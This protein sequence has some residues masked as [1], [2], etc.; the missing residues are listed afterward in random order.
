MVLCI[1]GCSKDD[2]AVIPEAAVTLAPTFEPT[3]TPTVKVK[4]ELPALENAK[5]RP[6]AK[7]GWLPVFRQAIGM[8]EKCIAIT[9]DD[10]FQAGNMRSI[11]EL[12][13]EYGGK[14]TFFP[15]GK[16]ALLTEQ[17]KILREAYANG[18]EIENHTYTHN[19]LY[20]GTDEELAQEIYT[21]QLVL[22]YVLG[23]DYT[24]HF[25]RPRGGDARNDQRIHAYISQL[26][27]YYGIAHWSTV[28][29]DSYQS[30]T[31]GLE[32]GAIYLFHTTDKD[33]EMLRRFIPYA[34][35]QGYTF[36]TLNEM[37]GCPENEVRPLT[38]PI[39]VDTSLAPALEPYETVLVELKRG[40]YLY[41]V[42]VL[43][44]RL[45]ELGW[46]EGGADGVFGEL[47]EAAVKAVQAYLGLEADGKA[48]VSL[49]ELLY[50]DSAPRNTVLTDEGS[51]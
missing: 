44:S 36:V 18:M 17:G 48:S 28:Y 20:G 9:V 46:L 6:T 31:D 43:Q 42:K 7:E 14:L 15:I 10:C 29:E 24:C 33:L 19:G 47:T 39:T 37:F 51:L 11:M 49:Q 35:S 4:V 50:S 3:P 16:N 30:L 22:S 38:E 32:P 23:V 25:L 1:R 21:E 5:Y 13:M 40:N 27:N 8:T 41:A 12:V 2:E 45:I 34:Y 26:G